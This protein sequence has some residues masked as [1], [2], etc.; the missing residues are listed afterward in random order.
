[1]A[2]ADGQVSSRFDA[3]AR[4]VIVD[5]ADGFG[6]PRDVLSRMYDAFFTSKPVGQGCGLGLFLCQGIVVELRS[7]IRVESQAGKGQ[8]ILRVS[9]RGRWGAGPGFRPR[10][11]LR[12]GLRPWCGGGGR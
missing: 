9:L 5:V 4:R 6:I 1:M 11:S 7:E 12:G 2:T 3:T 10:R 8:S